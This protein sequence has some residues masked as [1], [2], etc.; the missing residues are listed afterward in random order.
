MRKE[1]SNQVKK[2]SVK[3]SFVIKNYMVCKKG[4]KHLILLVESIIFN[5]FTCLC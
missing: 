1:Y 5:Q 2:V 3:E 4:R